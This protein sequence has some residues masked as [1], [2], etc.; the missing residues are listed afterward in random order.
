MK[1]LRVG[2]IFNLPQDRASRSSAASAEEGLRD[3]ERHLLSYIPASLVQRVV[4]D[5]TEPDTPWKENFLGAV[6][7]VDVSGFTALSEKLKSE[8]GRGGS[9]LLNQYM[10][11]YF[12]ELIQVV[13][14]SGGDVIKFA[15]DALQVVWRN[16]P[17][18]NEL[19]PIASAY[20][21][22]AGE[23]RSTVGP[24][25]AP[26]AI[27]ATAADLT[28]LGELLVRA[29]RCCM[30]LL[31]E[32]NDFSPVDGVRLTLHVGIGAGPMAAFCVGGEGGRWEYFVAGEPIEQ[33]AIAT[34][35]AK[36][37]QLVL[38][39][40]A[41]GLLGRLERL[42]KPAAGKGSVRSSRDESS[43]RHSW[44]PRPVRS[45]PEPA[46]RPSAEA[47]ADL[48]AHAAELLRA[49]TPV[50]AGGL[51]LARGAGGRSSN[52]A[53][54]SHG[55]RLSTHSAASKREPEP[56]MLFGRPATGQTGPGE[57]A[58][59]RT[60]TGVMAV[61]SMQVAAAHTH[62]IREA[63]PK[64]P[65]LF[66][67][68][69]RR[70]NPPPVP[71]AAG[72]DVAAP[73]AGRWSLH[74]P[75]LSQ[76]TVFT[77][78]L[79]GARASTRRSEAR[80]SENG[81]SVAEGSGRADGV[82]VGP[83]ALRVLRCFV[84]ALIDERLAAGQAG[85]W[86]SEHR[87][88]T[89][90][91]LK[92]LGL[93]RKPCE[94]AGLGSTHAA[95]RAV[96]EAFSSRGGS[97]LRLITDDKGTRFLVGFGLPGQ[98]HGD[99]VSRAVMAAVEAAIRLKRIPAP[100]FEVAVDDD[101]DK[102]EGEEP[103]QSRPA[104]TALTVRCAVGI[105]T[106]RAF[107]GEAGCNIRREYTLM[108][109]SV[110]MAARLMQAAEKLGHSI[111]VDEATSAATP[112]TAC[113]FA[114][115]PAIVVKGRD[116][117]LPIFTPIEARARTLELATLLDRRRVR[118]DS[119]PPDSGG[120][121]SSPSEA[122]SRAPAALGAELLGAAGSRRSSLT[123]SA[124]GDGWGGRGPRVAVAATIG[125]ENERMAIK[126]ALLQVQDGR[127]GA[128]V[129]LGEAG[130]GKT[131]MTQVL[132]HLHDD[133]FPVI[134]IS[135]SSEREEGELSCF[136]PLFRRL[137]CDAT[138]QEL[139]RLS[140]KLYS[141]SAR[142]SKPAS[143]KSLAS[144]GKSNRRLPT[145]FRTEGSGSKSQRLRPER[146]ASPELS[147]ARS[148][149]R[150]EGSRGA[151]KGEQS[152]SVSQPP[153]PPG[154]PPPSSPRSSFVPPSPPAPDS[155]LP[156]P[157]HRPS[158]VPPVG[159]RTAAP[160]HR[161]PPTLPPGATSR[162]L[163]P[164]KAPHAPPPPAPPRPPPAQDDTKP[165]T[166]LSA[167]VSAGASDSGSR[168]L[169]PP[170][171]VPSVSFSVSDLAED[172]W[173]SNQP[174]DA[175]SA[176]TSR[177]QWKRT[178]S[179]LHRMK[180]K[181]SVSDLGS[182]FSEPSRK[183]TSFAPGV[184]NGGPSAGPSSPV[185]S[186]R[187]RKSASFASDSASAPE[188]SRKAATKAKQDSPAQGE[189]Q[190]RRR[191]SR[192]GKAVGAAVASIYTD[193]FLKSKGA[194]SP[195]KKERSKGKGRQG[196]GGRH[197][198][199]TVAPAPVSPYAVAPNGAAVGKRVSSAGRRL[200][201]G[202]RRSSTG[203]RRSTASQGRTP[204]SRKSEGRTPEQ[205]A[206]DAKLLAC[207]RWRT[208]NLAIQ[209]WTLPLW[210][211]T[212]RG[213]SIRP[214]ADAKLLADRTVVSLSPL[215]TPVLPTP[216]NANSATCKLSGA[217]RHTSTLRVISQVLQ[218]KLGGA[219]AAL[220]ISDAEHMDASSWAVLSKVLRDM[221]NLLV[222]LEL[223]P[224]TPRPAG[225][226]AVLASEQTTIIRLPG[227]REDE[228][229][230][231][232]ERI[233]GE[234]SVPPRLAGFIHRRCDGNP[235]YAMELARSL[236]QEGNIRL[237]SAGEFVLT[238]SEL[239]ISLPTTIEGLTTSRID[240]LP[241]EQQ[242]WLKLSSVLGQHFTVAVVH[243]LS[244][245]LPVLAGPNAA[246]SAMNKAIAGLIAV[247]MLR[248]TP[249]STKGDFEHAHGSVHAAA[250]SLL[251]AELKAT[252]HTAAAQYYDEFIIAARQDAQRKAEA[253]AAASSPSRPG[254]GGMRARI[255]AR[256]ASA[257]KATL[258]QLGDAAVRDIG[259]PARVTGRAP[260]R[261]QVSLSG[262]KLIALGE[263]ELARKARHHWVRAAEEGGDAYVV[264]NA[265]RHLTTAVDAELATQS[266]GALAGGFFYTSL[267]HF[268][269]AFMS[270]REGSL[271]DGSLRDDSPDPSG[272]ERH[273]SHGSASLR[274]G[275]LRSTFGESTHYDSSSSWVM[276]QSISSS[277]S[278]L[279][280]EAS[281]SSMP[282][283]SSQSLTAVVQLRDHVA[284]P[285][286][287]A[288]T[289]GS[290]A[291]SNALEMCTV[292]VKL[293][294]SSHAQPV[295]LGPAHRRL[296][297]AMLQLGQ[298]DEARDELHAALLALGRGNVTPL[299]SLAIRRRLLVEEFFRMVDAWTR[300]RP[301]V[302]DGPLQ[303]AH[304]VVRLEIA[305][306]YLLCATL[307]QTHAPQLARLRAL[308]ALWHAMRLSYMHPT[309]PHSHELL[310]ELARRRGRRRIAG[311]LL[312]TAHSIATGLRH[313]SALVSPEPQS[314]RKQMR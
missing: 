75:A 94:P 146:S 282:T 133:S 147:A 27:G 170:M 207:K 240:L 60:V 269:R 278:K 260:E 258:I 37:G 206:R 23:R 185:G 293:L 34:D 91:F 171:R 224:N 100:T 307:E 118:P 254:W 287:F 195:T 235:L 96:Q 149:N 38:S 47:E 236:L 87:V 276:Q 137:L 233:L 59:R 297:Q 182:Q 234:G 305:Q 123:A 74:M 115:L 212:L 134:R 80:R 160:V 180:S 241:A 255:R 230:T 295:L 187:S 138:I 21:D 126:K 312:K 113:T 311:R 117:P 44:L 152:V 296:G 121:A 39:P 162:P 188:H 7:F 52:L 72:G 139:G 273:P 301:S 186:A 105:T 55:A 42:G 232:V 220:V 163:S 148:L 172:T 203:D 43:I 67:R 192:S 239:D 199:A 229:V 120:S 15:G 266:D 173:M 248:A 12:D 33:M 13:C 228:I 153:S 141:I 280:I 98:Q 102:E 4:A 116:E 242:M 178:P 191:L 46:A 284:I 279:A 106:G 144:P 184:K 218:M 28:S 66:R 81:G 310:A 215:L 271:R 95:V 299:G 286:H 132:S 157:T 298:L 78:H 154:S 314:H 122:G 251:P 73:P 135:G 150:G 292:M 159:M 270:V 30:Q 246:R 77:Q 57:K 101:S 88:I 302:L 89:T 214:S 221:P 253:A 24:A 272:Q 161:K 107:C 213:L 49:G 283:H 131:Q 303:G 288:D 285:T 18:P 85:L 16:P 263:M 274:S 6:A 222:V 61:S 259:G 183:S 252:L 145:L 69:M 156:A 70:A 164:T 151:A 198:A 177:V 308:Q 119:P 25:A 65:G 1:K 225:A 104:P 58:V 181:A 281:A 36:A 262:Q 22:M 226:L 35:L 14:E 205:R 204:F 290:V 90:V 223:Q 189:R 264:Q 63:P 306:A 26:A 48:A 238:V 71:L 136:R 209:A 50:G 45:S 257:G 268:G 190:N 128:L 130:M 112:P 56:R 155:L 202:E 216:L 167:S 237:S 309:L 111:L 294:R 231:L 140:D 5:P 174:S 127:G 166:E 103:E 277:C 110:N 249:M 304:D 109:S 40:H 84:P 68:Q 62:S 99:E 194:L 9:E 83:E 79:S 64:S 196:E 158:T 124:F 8:V 3:A 291:T 129:L 20:G 2:Q 265:V 210:T 169:A 275:S 142:G 243:E 11:S 54:R 217:A 256:S 108:G 10:N 245:S 250:Y 267:G 125:R 208:A 41:R 76:A 93:G 176:D 53:R 51:L 165:M 29:A 197:S 201:K 92:L 17:A 211:V 143:G 179:P 193:S 19:L 175:T 244:R 313:S 32:L 114:S 261:Q 227:L 97:V 289:D 168:Q 82:V 31:N 300:A 86:V 219:P 200:S 247:G